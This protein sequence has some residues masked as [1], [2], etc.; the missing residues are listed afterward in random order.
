MRFPLKP[1]FL[2]EI[3]WL[4]ANAALGLG[5]P[6]S[7]T[8]YVKTV[9]RPDYPTPDNMVSHI[10]IFLQDDVVVIISRRFFFHLYIS[11]YIV[12]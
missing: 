11:C 2:D 1:I 6:F 4:G 9:T 12:C 7:S 5:L 8:E 10:R 3:L